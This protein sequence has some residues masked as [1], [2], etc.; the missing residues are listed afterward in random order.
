MLGAGAM[1]AAG[2]KI[3]A[4]NN[5][6]DPADVLERELVP[7][8]RQALRPGAEGRAGSSVIKPAKPKEIAA[9]QHRMS[10]HV[11]NVESV[12]WMFAYY[13]TEWDV[14]DRL[15]RARPAHRAGFRASVA[16]AFCNTAIE[17]TRRRRR[18]KDVDAREQRAVAQGRHPPSAG[19]D[20]RAPA[21]EE[22]SRLPEGTADGQCPPSLSIR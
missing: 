13:P 22:N 21:G 17:Q 18:T 7:A 10:T 19:M 2:N 1:I 20:V 5:I 11:L 4:D 15:Q 3:V 16:D 8:G 9:T 14:L 12:G 6:A